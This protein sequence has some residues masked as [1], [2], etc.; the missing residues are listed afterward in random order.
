MPELKP[1]PF[2]GGEEVGFDEIVYMRSVENC[3]ICTGCGIVFTV[4][5]VDPNLDDLAD[6]WNRRANDDV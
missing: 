3:I 1:C 5:W 2:C 6:K 4:E